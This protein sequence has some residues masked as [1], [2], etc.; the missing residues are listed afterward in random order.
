[1]LDL[2]CSVVNGIF[3]EFWNF[4]L[5]CMGLSVPF[6]NGWCLAI[7]GRT[8]KHRGYLRLWVL[9]RRYGSILVQML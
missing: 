5:F 1:M 4:Q 8:S 2:S 3:Q 6:E 9:Q 7:R